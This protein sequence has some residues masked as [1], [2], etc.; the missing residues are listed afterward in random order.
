VIVDLK[1]VGL[2][3]IRQCFNRL[4][5]PHLADMDQ[6][7]YPERLGTLF[8]IHAPLL[9]SAMWGIVRPFLAEETAA[10]MRLYRCTIHC[11]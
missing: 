1:G 6:Y 11:Q 7:H 3:Q 2:G 5:Q 10:K 8:V 9:F 4:F